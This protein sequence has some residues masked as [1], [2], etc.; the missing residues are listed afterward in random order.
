L[1]HT[2]FISLIP[3]ILLIFLIQIVGEIPT[4]SSK[5]KNYTTQFLWPLAPFERSRDFRTRHGRAL[6]FLAELVGGPT[7]MAFVYMGLYLPKFKFKLY[8]KLKAAIRKKNTTRP[9][10][11]GMDPGIQTR[12]GN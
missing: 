5:N 7:A 1:L 2:D 6:E 3:L 11:V 12:N 10:K 8:R 4:S 9:V